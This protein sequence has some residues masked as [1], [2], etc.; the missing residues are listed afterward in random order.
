[1]VGVVIDMKFLQC[2]F[3]YRYFIVF[4]IIFS[5]KETSY[6][7][8]DGDCKYVRVPKFL[9]KMLF[10][11]KKDCYIT[12]PSLVISSLYFTAIA[13]NIVVTIIICVYDLD[14]T[15]MSMFNNISFPIFVLGLFIYVELIFWEWKSNRTARI[16]NFLI[17]T[18]FEL[19][20]VIAFT[21]E[22]IMN[23][24]ELRT[25]ILYPFCS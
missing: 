13:V 10:P 1:M 24:S 23:S 21:V 3:Q 4:F 18:I 16:L 9:A 22:L 17:C 25:L 19:Y 8:D 12:L 5:A 6:T 14:F 2:V 7:R 20:F 11:F 15:Y